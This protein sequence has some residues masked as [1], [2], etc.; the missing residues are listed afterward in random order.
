[1]KTKKT[2]K[3]TNKQNII[4]QNIAKQNYIIKRSFEM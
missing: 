4:D 2:N 1:M 3:Q